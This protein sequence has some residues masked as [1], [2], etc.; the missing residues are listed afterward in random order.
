MLHTATARSIVAVVIG[1]VVMIAVPFH[2]GA[3]FDVAIRDPALRFLPERTARYTAVVAI[4]EAS[5]QREGAWPWHSPG[6]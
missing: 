3:P 5:L 2:L 1:V 4:D 6:R